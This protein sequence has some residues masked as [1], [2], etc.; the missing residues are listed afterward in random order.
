MFAGNST[1]EPITLAAKFTNISSKIILDSQN[2]LELESLIIDDEFVVTSKI[3]NGSD[4]ISKSSND[5]IVV[6]KIDYFSEFDVGLVI[7]IVV[8]IAIGISLLL[9]F[10][11]K[12]T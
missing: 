8:G 9:I 3:N 10:R 1:T 11:L 5:P 7:G 6:S 12:N 4:M 2:N